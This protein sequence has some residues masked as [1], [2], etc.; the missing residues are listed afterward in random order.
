M[1]LLV[2]IVVRGDYL[3]GRPKRAAGGD[4]KTELSARKAELK[5]AP[6][7]CLSAPCVPDVPYSFS[8]KSFISAS[9]LRSFFTENAPKVVA[10]ERATMRS[11]LLF[12]T[13]VSVT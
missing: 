11:T 10:S 8:S 5:F 9:V 7:V 12:T 1:A 3:V 6:Y 2:V 4:R 13:P